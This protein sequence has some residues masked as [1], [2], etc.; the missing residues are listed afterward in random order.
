MG[1]GGRRM[2]GRFVEEAGD[3]GACAVEDVLDGFG[4]AARLRPL[5]V[6]AGTLEGDGCTSD[7]RI[8]V[9]DSVGVATAEVH[10]ERVA[11]KHLSEP[12]LPEILMC[13]KVEELPLGV[14]IETIL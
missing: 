9:G 13:D 2:A 6:G 4:V 10:A 5:S 11:L 7:G 8:G 3:D 14:E 12:F 1:A